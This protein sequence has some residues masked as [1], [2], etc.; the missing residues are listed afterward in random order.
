MDDCLERLS[1][2]FFSARWDFRFWVPLLKLPSRRL[3]GIGKLAGRVPCLCI[4][5]YPSMFIYTS[6]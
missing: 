6:P 2:V 5:V 1:Q 3:N 4:S